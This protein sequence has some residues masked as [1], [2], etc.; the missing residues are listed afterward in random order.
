V[1]AEAVGERLAAIARKRQVL[2][3]THLAVIAA[4]ADQHLVL[5]KESGGGRTRVQVEELRGKAREEELA[6]MLAGRAGGEAARR[7][8]RT[9]LAEGNRS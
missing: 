5:R 7:T 3:V 1:V 4:R 8:A 2:V 6:R 9:I